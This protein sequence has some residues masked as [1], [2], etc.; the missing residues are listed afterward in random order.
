MKTPFWIAIEAWPC[1]RFV[2]RGLLRGL[3]ARNGLDFVDPYRSRV[4]LRTIWAREYPRGVITTCGPRT[5]AWFLGI[6]MEELGRHP[7]LTMIRPP[8]IGDYFTLSDHSQNQWSSIARRWGLI[9]PLTWK[10]CAS[11]RRRYLGG[12]RMAAHWR[13]LQHECRRF[14]MHPEQRDLTVLMDR[15]ESAS[16]RPIVWAIRL[17]QR[18]E[19]DASHRIGNYGGGGTLSGTLQVGSSGV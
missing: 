15:Y 14:Y 17:Y 3:A 4:D 18:L 16:L 2:R 5:I 19:R 8:N 11:E 10:S 7:H 12:M 13:T 1:D 6:P 9:H